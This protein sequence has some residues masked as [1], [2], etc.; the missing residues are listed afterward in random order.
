MFTFLQSGFIC[1]VV[2]PVWTIFLLQTILAMRRDWHLAIGED[3]FVWNSRSQN[4]SSEHPAHAAD[5]LQPNSLG[6]GVHLRDCKVKFPVRDLQL[7]SYAVYFSPT[8]LDTAE[9]LQLKGNFKFF[10]QIHARLL[11]SNSTP[12]LPIFPATFISPGQF[13]VDL[14]RYWNDILGVA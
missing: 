3:A 4:R 5:A 14:Q 11:K 2:L 9:V 6:E 8:S 7:D 1:H 13:A 12:T 10:K